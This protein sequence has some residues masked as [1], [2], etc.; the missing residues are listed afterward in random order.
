MHSCSSLI[1]T[2]QPADGTGVFLSSHLLVVPNNRSFILTWLNETLITAAKALPWSC[3]PLPARWESEW[4]RTNLEFRVLSHLVCFALFRLVSNQFSCFPT[5]GFV[6]RPGVPLQKSPTVT[7]HAL[8]VLGFAGRCSGSEW[9]QIF[10][11]TPFLSHETQRHLG[12]CTKTLSNKCI[13]Y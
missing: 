3:Q 9:T 10:G 8:L 12:K 4:L 13:I 5:G 1:F 6:G 7:S 2:W 11:I